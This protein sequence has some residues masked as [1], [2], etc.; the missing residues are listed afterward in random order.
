LSGCSTP[1]H[2]IMGLFE[3]NETIGHNMTMQQM[4]HCFQDFSWYALCD[5]INEKQCLAW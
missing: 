1:L 4:G 2:V 5:C 3:A